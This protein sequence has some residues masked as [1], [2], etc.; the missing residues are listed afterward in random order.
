VGGIN[1]TATDWCPRA[2]N[3]GG[4]HV[5]RPLLYDQV[6]DR[7]MWGVREVSDGSQIR[8]GFS[9]TYSPNPN[10]KPYPSAY[11]GIPP[12][13]GCTNEWVYIVGAARGQNQ[14]VALLLTTHAH[15]LI[16]SHNYM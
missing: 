5:Q 1:V 10:L 6:V 8:Q 13:C 16:T 11:P 15:A 3:W 9:P 7:R 2:P 4:F 14:H 12:P